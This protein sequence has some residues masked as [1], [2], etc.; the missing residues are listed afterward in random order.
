[1]FSSTT[2]VLNAPRKA[3]TFA[4]SEARTLEYR[5]YSSLQLHPFYTPQHQAV[6]RSIFQDGKS[7]TIGVFARAGN[8]GD[9]LRIRTSSSS[10][11]NAKEN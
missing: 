8:D 9:D 6:V 3:G 11:R 4:L 5:N 2:F 10:S 7:I 1:M